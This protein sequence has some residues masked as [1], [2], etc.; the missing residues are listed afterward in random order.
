MKMKTTSQR[1]R[2]LFLQ[3]PRAPASIDPAATG[4]N[5]RRGLAREPSAILAGRRQRRPMSSGST[6]CNFRRTERG[7]SD[8]GSAFFRSIAMLGESA[9]DDDMR[10]PEK[11]RN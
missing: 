3:L 7:T 2:L 5:N 4:P 9:I 8:D 11:E 10:P 1:I 6:R